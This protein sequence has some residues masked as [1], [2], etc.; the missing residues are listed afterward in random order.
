MNGYAEDIDSLLDSLD[1]GE[2]EERS[3]RTR[4]Q[5]AV[6]TPSRRGSF[7]PRPQP[8]PASQGQVQ[9]AARNLDS[10]IDTLSAAVKALETRTNGLATEQDRVAAVMR[11]EAEERKKGIDTTKADLQQTKML[12]VLLPML[13]QQ[14]SEIQDPTTP[15]QTLRDNTGQP[16]RVVTQSQN[17]LASLLP[18]LLLMPG[19]SGADGAKGGLDMTTLLLVVML[20]GRR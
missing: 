1:F 8:A 12:A 16:V 10:K 14:A 3:R 20:A 18:I 5:P 19:T 2:F 15:G 7:T 17:Q 11:K 9:A 13:T 6:R 4:R